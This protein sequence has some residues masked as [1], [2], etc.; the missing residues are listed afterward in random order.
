MMWS[1]VAFAQKTEP[2][3]R[4][5]N[6]NDG[7]PSSTVYHAFQD[8]KGY[9][10]FATANGV[11]RFDGY[12]FQNFDLQSG[13]VDNDVFE[14]YE[15]Y[16]HRIW[17]IPMSGKLCY[18]E[19]GSVVAYKYNNLI[20]KYAPNG[21]GP[22]KGSFYVD[23]LDFVYVSLKQFNRF[24]ISPEGIFTEVKGGD[25]YSVD[26]LETIENKILI[27]TQNSSLAQKV[28]FRGLKSKFDLNLKE[29][30]GSTNAVHVHIFLLNAP[31]SSVILSINGNL[32]RIKD[33]II[34]GR[35]RYGEEIIWTSLDK[36][37][38]LW[39][40]PLSGGVECFTS[41][42]SEEKPVRSFF[43]DYK[44]TSVLCDYE[45]AYWFTTLNNGVFYCQDINVLKHNDK[46]RLS[47][48]R[49]N[50]I[51]SSKSG[52]YI[53]Y[54]F[55]FVDLLGK[56]GIKRYLSP[57]LNLPRNSVRSF[58]VDSALSR[59][60]VC[61]IVNLS[62]I[63]GDFVKYMGLT[64]SGNVIYPKKIIR[65]KH[66]GYWLA[67][68]KGLVKIENDK[69]VY[70][71]YLNNEFTGLIYD[72]VEDYSG[73]VW[74]CTING[75]WLYNN[76]LFKYLGEST[77]IFSHTCY[78]MIINP[79][80]SSLWIGTNGAGIIVERFGEAKQ[81]TTNEGLVSNSISQ[82]FYSDNNIWVATRNGL[83]RLILDGKGYRLKNYTRTSGLL[84]NE[85]TSISEYNDTI[86]LGTPEGVCFFNKKMTGEFNNPPRVII[87]KFLAKDKLIDSK[88]NYIEFDYNENSFSI[89]FIGFVYRNDGKINYRYRM[90]GVDSAWIFTQTPNCQYNGLADGKYKFE[91]EAQSYNGIWSSSPATVEFVIHP[92][93]W[94]RFWFLALVIILFSGLFFM[95]Y[96]FRI[97]SINKRNELL[98]NINLYKQQS[99]RQQMNPHFIFNTLN[100][101]QLYILEKDS[102]SSH[103]YL[104]KFAKLMRKTLDNSLYSSIPIRDELEALSI[105]LDLEKLRV[106]DRFEYSI[107]YGGDE[108]ILNYGIPT[109]LIQ[110]FVE[111]AIWHGISLRNDQL[112]WIKIMVQEDGNIIKCIV[113]DN[114]VG[115]VVADQIKQSKNR[116]HKSRASQITQQRIDLLSQMF[117][118]KFSIMYTDLYDSSGV[119]TGTKVTI[120]IPKDLKVN[121]NK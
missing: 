81:I 99:L 27:A 30:V 24:V 85:I 9:I 55:A 17:F 12:K 14:I 120:T 62:W 49:I 121:S 92:P 36:N 71:S 2:V 28:R 15:D 84:T 109:L 93:F 87:S 46:F 50:A 67:T 77:P 69:V 52:V 31:D 57:K 73:R 119:A 51:A 113:E 91:V 45:G 75:I 114:G 35:K 96:R 94:K 95:F 72:L 58:L 56:T 34:L 115:R 89:D 42:F 38:N 68:T 80:D 40:S 7:L 63:E 18:F 82:L 16:K 11:S 33:S 60:W 4:R 59:V 110:P 102:I 105:Y 53:G 108:H 21:R 25:E 19:N 3:F 39:V 98:H 88:L 66:G 26:A 1:I 54:E 41:T 79:K 103:K 86:F 13:L 22:I 10:W 48:D 64:P 37:G 116:E 97:N 20:Q 70:E 117:R 76:G 43:N 74:F 65:S 107:D 83:T 101:I 47:D 5:Y 104:T 111:N 29:L 8:S 44:V 6:V 90:L 61:S 118:E 32:N 106:E 112:G 23:T 78:S 100:S